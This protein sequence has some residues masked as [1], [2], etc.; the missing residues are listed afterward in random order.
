MGANMTP[1]M[2]NRGR[3]VLGVKM[4]LLPPSASDRVHATVGVAYCHALRRCCRKAVSGRL[5]AWCGCGRGGRRAWQLTRGSSAL[6]LLGLLAVRVLAR[7]GVGVFDWGVLRHGG[8]SAVIRATS[9]WEES[10]CQPSL[11]DAG[12]AAGQRLKSPSGH[13]HLATGRATPILQARSP[14]KAHPAPTDLALLAAAMHCLLRIA[15]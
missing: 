1:T 9:R 13:P 4:G 15:C 2:K 14:S 5:S 7:D 6:G 3:T 11:T 10:R 12:D 8:C